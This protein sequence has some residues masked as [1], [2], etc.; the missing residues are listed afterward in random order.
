MAWP[1][2]VILGTS[3]TSMDAPAEV[4]EN[5]VNGAVMNRTS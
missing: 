1:I 4:V 2:A 5:P 3:T